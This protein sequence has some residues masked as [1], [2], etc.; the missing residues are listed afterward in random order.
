MAEVDELDHSDLEGLDPGIAERIQEKAKA[1]ASKNKK[2]ASRALLTYQG[3]FQQMHGF[4]STLANVTSD[5]V[6]VYL[7]LFSVT[8]ANQ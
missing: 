2:H 1:K 8:D 5:S 7:K 4:L 3:F 6:C